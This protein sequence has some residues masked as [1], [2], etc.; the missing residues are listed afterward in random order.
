MNSR[1]RRTFNRTQN[2]AITLYAIQYKKYSVLD[3]A[4]QQAQKW[5]KKKC[6]G[7]YNTKHYWDKSIFTFQLE[8]DA[9]IFALKW[10]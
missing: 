4:T 9:V 7:M 1:Q 5:C 8:H 2:H 3:E 10:L 6:K